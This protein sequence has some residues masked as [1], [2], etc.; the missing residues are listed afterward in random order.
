RLKD[1]AEAKAQVEEKLRAKETALRA[2]AEQREEVERSAKN[3]ARKFLFAILCLLLLCLAALGFVHLQQLSM[4]SRA[5][6]AE[7]E[8]LLNID[9]AAALDRA[10]HAWQRSHTEPAHLAVAH[11]FPKGL[12]KLSG[13]VGWIA[14]AAFSPDESLVV[15]ASYDGTARLWS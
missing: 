14:H 7:A 15:T 13:H 11:A 4:E 5:L 1:A 10:I 6:A 3:R 2:A 9:S 12:Y 8:Q